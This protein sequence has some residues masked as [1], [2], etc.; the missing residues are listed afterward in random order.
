MKLQKEATGSGLPHRHHLLIE[1]VEDPAARGD[2]KQVI[3]H[4][5]WGGRVNRP[6][7]LALSQAWEEKEHKP[8]Q[9]ILND[10]AVLL[11]L[12]HEFRT[13]DLFSLVTPENIE[14]FLRRKLEQTGFFG[15]RFRENA[16][17][18]LLLPKSSFKRRMPLWLIRLR[19][20]ELLAA[21]RAYDDFPVLLETWRTCL[22]DEFDL[23]HAKAMLDDIREGAIRVSETVTRTASPFAGGLVWKQ[24]N[25]YMYEDDTPLLARESAL[26]PD[27]IKEI[28]FSAHLRPKIPPEVIRVLDGKLK[29]T[30][31]GYT[32][33]SA[34]ELLDWV[35]ERLLI[36]EPEWKELAA[37]IRR[38]LD[39]DAGEWLRVEARKLFWISWPGVR[40]PLLSS[41]E[42]LPKVLVAFRLHPDVVTLEAVSPEESSGSLR[43]RIG[44][45]MHAPPYLPRG[46]GAPRGSATRAPLGGVRPGERDVFDF[47]QHGCPT[48][49][50]WKKKDC[51]ESSGHNR[52]AAR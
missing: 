29:R 21:V 23:P 26:R 19:S 40:H 39:Q 38:D 15:A 52:R 27:L 18:A 35:K 3:L 10:D 41:L 31:P 7:A 46:R 49:A 25:K 43:R 5:F 14:V 51:P 22:E 37:A 28:L 13:E 8:L 44:L 16:E 4:T 20:K 2:L 30:A 32:P 36:P 50:L 45:A 33:G 6:F 48:T 9:F 1:H 12:P 24:T 17:R 34:L 11:M 47:R 42:A